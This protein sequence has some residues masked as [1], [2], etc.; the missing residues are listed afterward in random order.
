VAPGVRANTPAKIS[1]REYPGRVFDAMLTRASF[2]LD[3]Q[4]RTMTVELRVPNPKGEL[5]VGMYTEVKLSFP[6]PHKTYEVPA[7]ALYNDGSGLRVAVVDSSDTVRFSKV[8]IERDTGATLQLASGLQP[9]DRVVR[10][11]SAS[12]QQ[13]AHVKVRQVKAAAGQG[14]APGQAP[15]QGSGPA[16]T[17]SK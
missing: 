1:V 10:L 17:P 3:S 4:T 14:Q 13:G 5:I 12:L 16:Q 6:L 9:D 15:T 11:A 8:V 7:T 2:T